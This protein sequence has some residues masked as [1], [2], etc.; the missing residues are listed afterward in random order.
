ML[1]RRFDNPLFI[2]RELYVPWNDSVVR[3]GPSVGGRYGPPFNFTENSTFCRYRSPVIPVE[4]F[5]PMSDP[6]GDPPLAGVKEE[7]AG[8]RPRTSLA[9]DQQSGGGFAGTHL[10]QQ[11]EGWAA[12][13][14]RVKIDVETLCLFV[15]LAFVGATGFMIMRP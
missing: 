9:A 1:L 4:V 14:G 10:R 12:V 3:Q 6:A 13:S 15:G 5:D 7:P 8:A 2:E 11:S